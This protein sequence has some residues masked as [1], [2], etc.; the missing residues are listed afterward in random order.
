MPACAGMTGYFMLSL[1]ERNDQLAR[2]ANNIRSEREA[3]S[4]FFATPTKA[5]RNSRSL[6][7]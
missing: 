6:I 5:G 7:T 2:L 1:G 4:G 3:Y